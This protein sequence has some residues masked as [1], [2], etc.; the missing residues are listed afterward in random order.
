MSISL[1]EGKKSPKVS[2]KEGNFIQTSVFATNKNQLL[3]GLAKVGN[4][5]RMTSTDGVP[6]S[7]I[8]MFVGRWTSNQGDFVGLEIRWL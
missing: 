6:D 1:L 5:G 7:H 2:R 4:V 8:H 3:I